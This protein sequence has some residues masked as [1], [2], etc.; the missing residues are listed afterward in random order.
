MAQLLNLTGEIAAIGNLQPE[1]VPALDTPRVL[2]RL[3][4][5]PLRFVL[6]AGLTLEECRTLAPAFMEQVTVKINGS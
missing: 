4:G 3:D 6:I 1:D 5:Q 2:I